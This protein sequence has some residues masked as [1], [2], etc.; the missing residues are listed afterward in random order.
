MIIESVFRKA[1]LS[2]SLFKC[3]CVSMHRVELLF[4]LFSPSLFLRSFFES[5]HSLTAHFSVLL[6]LAHLDFYETVLSPENL[7]PPL[8]LSQGPGDGRTKQAHEWNESVN[9]KK[10]LPLSITLNGQI[11]KDFSFD[12][13]NK[14]RMSAVTI[15]VP[16]CPW[17]PGQENKVKILKKLKIHN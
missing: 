17:S 2:P 1:K 13:R 4:L 16:H 3:A 15:S 10:K 12:I 7:K 11:Q 9:G 14:T 6:T 5:L 8:S